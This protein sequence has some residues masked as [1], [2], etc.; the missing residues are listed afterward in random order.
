MSH[1]VQEQLVKLGDVYLALSADDE[2][3]NVLWHAGS[4]DPGVLF[5]VL[6]LRKGKSWSREPGAPLE[7][8][9]FDDP[10]APSEAWTTYTYTLFLPEVDP[11]MPARLLLTK[12]GRPAAQKVNTILMRN[13]ASGP[14]YVNAFRLSSAERKNDKGRYAVAQV[15]VTQAEPEHVRQ[16]G[17]LYELIA[18]SLAAQRTSTTSGADEPAI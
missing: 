13:A 5:H 11:D 1:A 14:S 2:E 18:P 9:D 16:A 6:T 10:N 4:N 3:P 17:E 7:L 15:A 12:T 8:F